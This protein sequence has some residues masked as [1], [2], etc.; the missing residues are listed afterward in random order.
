[1]L[2]SRRKEGLSK[3]GLGLFPIGG[4]ANIGPQKVLDH[5]G[6]PILEISEQLQDM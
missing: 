1:M 6:S 4:K 3:P 2:K 5:W